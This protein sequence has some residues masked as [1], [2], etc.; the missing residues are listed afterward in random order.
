MAEQGKSVKLIAKISARSICGDLSEISKNMTEG[1]VLPLYKVTGM[2][3][4]Q[5]TGKGG[6]R[7]EWTALAGR[8]NV[9]RLVGEEAYFSSGRL[10]LPE[11]IQ[12]Y[13]AADM[14]SVDSERPKP[15][16]IDITVSIRKE[17]MTGG[18]KNAV[19]YVYEISMGGQTFG[20]VPGAEMVEP[21]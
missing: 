21:D 11:A 10:F 19:G 5:R 7:G 4:A 16:A 17:G 8:F 15:V 20:A 2:L 12:D 3:T 9:Q 13:V 6:V 18:R 1:S 14:Y